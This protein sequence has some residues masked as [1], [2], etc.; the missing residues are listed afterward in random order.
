MA[1]SIIIPVL[2]VNDGVLWEANYNENGE[3]VED[4]KQVT[5]SEIYLGKDLWTGPMGVEYTFSHLHINTLSSFESFLDRLSSDDD[6]WAALF[7]IEQIQEQ[8]NEKKIN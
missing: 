1:L 8:L 4:P 5:S 3:L 7:P 2:V 6:Y